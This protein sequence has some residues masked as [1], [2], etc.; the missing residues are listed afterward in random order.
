MKPITAIL[1][2]GLVLTATLSAAADP[3][4]PTI[5]PGERLEQILASRPRIDE[6]LTIE[7]AVTL[8]MQESPVIRGAVQEVEA[9]AGRLEATRAER[10][11]WVSANTF[12][13]GGSAA[14]IVGSPDAVQP[15]MVMG[16]PGGRFL[17]QNVSLMVPLFTGGRLKAMVRQAQAMKKGSEAELAAMRQEVALMVRTAYRETQ[18]RQ[19]TVRVYTVLLDQNRERQRIDLIAYE[20]EKIPRFY[21]LRNAA[22]VADAEQMLTNARRDVEVSLI[23]L[24]TLMGVHLQS[25]IELPA[26][27]DFRPAAAVLA[28]YGAAVPPVATELKS[29]GT[30]ISEAEMAQL[31]AVAEH[32]RPE[33]IAAAQRVMAG[34]EE[35]KIARSAYRPQIGLGVMGDFS[36]MRGEAPFGGSTFALVGSLPILDG[37]ARKAKIRTG[38]AEV[39]KLRADRT[40]I[41]LQVGQEITTAL[42]NLR[43]AERNVMTSR[44]A[45]TAATE[46]YRVA[47]LRYTSGKGINVEALDALSAQVRAQNNEIQALYEYNSAQDQLA[48]S[49]GV[50]VAPGIV[51]K[52]S[53]TS[54]S[55]SAGPDDV[56]M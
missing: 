9:A 40:Q 37:G 8:A 16:L 6:R 36:K 22:E 52:P 2:G 18:A 5:D 29:T 44:T 32:N 43:A 7:R 25:G 21:T 33:L 53:A 12:V 15:R 31:L 50:I 38:E 10:R 56:K 45:V 19:S 39:A 14:N 51:E 41:A 26:A 11:P 48:R 1:W 49:L 34:L 17:G 30:S 3:A 4:S 28:T 27:A 24:K 55:S 13:G 23:Q 47:Q 54:P 42:L 46:D 35:V 20:Q